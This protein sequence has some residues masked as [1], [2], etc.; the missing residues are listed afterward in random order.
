M[1]NQKIQLTNKQMAYIAT[2]LAAKEAFRIS[3]KPK[4]EWISDELL[5]HMKD[6]ISAYNSGAR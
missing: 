5:Y 6:A 1:E 2:Y 4:L 3:G